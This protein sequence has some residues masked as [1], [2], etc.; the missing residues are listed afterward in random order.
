[1]A[2]TTLQA[3]SALANISPAAIRAEM[4]RR[5]DEAADRTHLKNDWMVGAPSTLT[6][7]GA[8]LA[9][10]GF[11][12]EQSAGERFFQSSF[13]CYRELAACLPEIVADA[14]KVLFRGRR[15]WFPATEMAA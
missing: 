3:D 8:Y 13:A 15:A 12:D 7:V 11:S 2:F 10:L 4:V 5:I 14:R 6:A 1:M 9:S